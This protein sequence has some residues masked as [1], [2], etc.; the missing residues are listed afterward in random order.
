MNT[1]APAKIDIMSLTLEELRAAMEELGEPGYR[2]GQVFSWLQGKG[3]TDFHKFSDIPRP[4]QDKLAERFFTVELETARRQASPDG[5]EKFL[6][7]L[8]D[9]R[10]IET[11]HIPAAR[12]GTVCVSTQIGCKFACAFCASGFGGFSRNLSASEIVGQVLA[13]RHGFGLLVSHVVFMGMGEPLDNFDQVSRAVRILNSPKGPGIAA[14]RITIS[15]CG[16][17]PG[18]EKLKGLGLQVEL[19]VSLHAADN[20]VR[21][22]L[23]PINRTYPLERLTAA[24]RDYTRATGR[25]VTFEYALIAGVND[26]LE[27]A[28][29]LA[30]LARPLRAKV[31]LIP[32]SDV[33]VK[34]FQA[35]APAVVEAFRRRLEQKGLTVTVRRSKGG[36]IRAAC[37]Q[38]AGQA[39]G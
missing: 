8:A 9:G 26:S 35:S 19:S 1:P 10:F 12:R 37:G 30:G 31:N 5:A 16:L 18:I 11:V 2:A 21:S 13:L 36:D 7:K 33:G 17:V 15:T 39:R 38:L 25:Q 3:E 4:L 28:D 6:F 23:V 14:R 29:R 32:L 22:R 27:A 34:G 24:L 20:E